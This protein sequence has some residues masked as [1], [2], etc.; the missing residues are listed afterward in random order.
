ME[1]F[2]NDNNNLV[3]LHARGSTYSNLRQDKSVCLHK[4]FMNI[5]PKYFMIRIIELSNSHI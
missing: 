1:R 4:S 3:P 5:I 2:I